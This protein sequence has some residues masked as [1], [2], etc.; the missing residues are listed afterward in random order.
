MRIDQLTV[1]NFRRFE[2]CI[3]QLHPQFTLLVGDNGAGKTAI[4]DAL[5][6]GAGAYLLGIPDSPAP[7]PP[8]RQDYMRRETR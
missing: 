4:L 7:A 6:V 2:K 3:F 8:I 1:L 5:R